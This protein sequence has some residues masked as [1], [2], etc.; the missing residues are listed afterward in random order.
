[1]GTGDGAISFHSQLEVNEWRMI[2]TASWDRHTK[3]EINRIVLL[4]V[5]KTVVERCEIIDGDE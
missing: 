2:C 1:V 4:V 3:G 5:N